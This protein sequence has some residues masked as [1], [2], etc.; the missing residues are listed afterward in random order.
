METSKTDMLDLRVIEP[1][2]VEM[3][4]EVRASIV[5]KNGS[6]WMIHDHDPVEL[7]DFILDLGFTAQTYI[8]G[9]SEYRIFVGR[10]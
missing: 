7:Y 8:Y 5:E 2:L 3:F 4:V 10:Q 1:E 9:P 6:F